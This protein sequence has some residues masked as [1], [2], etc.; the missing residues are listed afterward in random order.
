MIKAVVGLLEGIRADDFQ[1]M[2]DTDMIMAAKHPKSVGLDGSP[3]TV[4]GT[5]PSVVAAYDVVDGS[6]LVSAATPAEEGSEGHEGPAVS[7]DFAYKLDPGLPAD[8]VAS[9]IEGGDYGELTL[10]SA[11]SDGKSHYVEIDAS[12]GGDLG[13]ESAKAEALAAAERALAYIKQGI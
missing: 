2:P 7:V 11:V 1:P 10:V 4:D 5:G 6:L 13:V 8:Q 9:V 12:Q 3:F